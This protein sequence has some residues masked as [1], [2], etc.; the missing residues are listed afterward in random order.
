[1][2][3]LKCPICGTMNRL[4][5]K[6]CYMCAGNLDESNVVEIV[7]SKKK[8]FIFILTFSFIIISILFY[9]I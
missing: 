4:S 2:K 5:K 8:L 6:S 7:K 1:M 9:F 3:K